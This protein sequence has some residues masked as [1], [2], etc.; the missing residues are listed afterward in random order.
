M[1]NPTS[2][3]GMSKF[4]I[5]FTPWS[6]PFLVWLSGPGTLE[7]WTTRTDPSSGFSFNPK[8]KIF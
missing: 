8:K 4:T 2:L 1:K 3:L 5:G 6:F 7:L